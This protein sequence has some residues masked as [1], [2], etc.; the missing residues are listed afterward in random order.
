MIIVI[1]LIAIIY[2]LVISKVK[3]VKR[4][5]DA[6]TFLNLYQKLSE[7]K[8]DHNILFRC[9]EGNKE[10]LIIVDGVIKDK[11]DYIAKDLKAVY[12]LDESLNPKKIEFN[13]IITD[14]MEEKRVSFEYKIDKRGGT[15]EILVQ[16]DKSVVFLGG[17]FK[18]SDKYEDL[19][20]YLE[21]YSELMDKVSR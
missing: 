15:K 2:S 18:N 11:V 16:L 1:V 12:K 9:L 14:Q 21:G 5:D 3:D 17:Y 7:Y 8:Y 10:C 4:S 20:K 19:D 6:I 13:S